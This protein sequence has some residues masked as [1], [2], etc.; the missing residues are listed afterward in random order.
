V[1]MLRHA[2]HA[3]AAPALA[4][5]TLLLAET[6]AAWAA[7]DNPKCVTFAR[8][9]LAMASRSGVFVW[10]EFFYSMGAEAAFS[11]EDRDGAQEFIEALRHVAGRGM[12]ATACY[13]SYCSWD[14]LLR[15]DLARALE[16]IEPCRNATDALGYPFARA[17]A[18]FASAQVLFARGRKED[19]LASLDES[20]HIAARL[21]EKLVTF[22]CDLFEADVSWDDD[23]PRALAALRRGLAY[24][25]ENGVYN[26]YWGQKSLMVR[27]AVLALEND[28]EPAYVRTLIARR[29]LHPG[30]LAARVEVW[31]WRYRVRALGSFEVVREPD[32]C[33]TSSPS[34]PAKG[35]RGMPLRLLQAIVAFGA[36]GVR[37]TQLV[38]ALWPHAEG[39]AGRRVFDT[40]L[41]RLRRQLGGEDLVQLREGRVYINERLCWLDVW[42]L[43]DVLADLD[44]QLGH[45]APVALLEQMAN[46]LV[47][48]YRGP[49]L[50][51]DVPDDA[52]VRG[53]RQRVEGRFRRAAD[54]L[55]AALQAA[56]QS[57]HA[58][59]LRKPGAFGDRANPSATSR[60]D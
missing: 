17:V 9:G 19:A 33:S 36:R 3:D 11:D 15:R 57:R 34:P 42:A 18:R 30:A 59:A 56:G 22:A 27:I 40:T 45:A 6:L 60:S 5:L 20:R 32:A 7:G 54:R 35:L 21:D 41:H 37:E 44:H 4:T 2:A 8:E 52:W 29:R 55:S 28:I 48:L 24:A 38:D 51:E 49:L 31:P 23:R 16:H 50:C 58:A 46:R 53:P 1:E 13:H 12:F 43:E 26:T 39:D 10:N 25:R 47:D 14:A